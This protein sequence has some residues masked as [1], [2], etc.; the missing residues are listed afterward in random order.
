M[1]MGAVCASL[2]AP[3]LA[4]AQGMSGR[5]LYATLS[6]ETGRTLELHGGTVHLVVHGGDANAAWQAGIERWIRRAAAAV[7]A[8]F[9]RFPVDRTGL[10]VRAVPGSRVRGGVSF[11]LDGSAVKVDVGVDATAA[12][13]DD[14]WVLTHEF[15]HLGFPDLRRRHLWLQEGSATYV[16]PIARIEA[17]QLTPARMWTD[18]LDDLPKGLPA[19]TDQGLDQTRT[20][21]STYWGGA[22]FCLLA[23]VRLRE[24]TNNL[25]GIQTALRAIRDA[26][27]GNTA[28]WS[29]EQTLSTGDRATR[30]TVLS[31]L[32]AQ[33]AL[34][35]ARIDLVGLLSRLGVRR[36][37]TGGAELDD[38]APLAPIRIGIT[39]RA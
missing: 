34:K 11:G 9:G 5:D 32:Y 36:S 37:S 1:T 12:V 26:S 7:S 22:L 16:E 39:A 38:T 13:L 4:T 10:L 8:Y 19:P 2:C 28:D 31:E 6:S 23:D 27:G 15:V 21:A 14:D 20:W 29:I 30:T 17:G 33:M 35:P 25:R 18:L 24:A 3:S